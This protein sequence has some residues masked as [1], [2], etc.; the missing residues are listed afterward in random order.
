MLQ[1]SRSGDRVPFGA[2]WLS[3]ALLFAGRVPLR[4]E[5]PLHERI[6]HFIEAGTPNFGKLAAGPAPDAEF[7]RRVYLD[8]TGTIPS[9]AQARAFLADAS[10]DKRQNLIDR[11][12]ASPEY[13]R[14]MQHVFNVVLMERR[15]DRFVPQA[16][17]HE[18]LR[19]SFAANKPWDQL[20]R[21]VLSADG[22]DPKLRPPAKFYLDRGADA[23]TLTK[24]IG[25][26]FLG[27]NLQCA[28]CHDH[29]LV[30]G[31]KQEHYY[32]IFAFLNRSSIFREKTGLVVL[33][34]KAEGEVAFQSVFDPT[35]LTRRTGPRLPDAAPVKE[36]T[37]PKGKEY[38]VAP[39]VGV[40]P[41]PRFSR[42]GPLAGL[43]TARDN[44]RFKRTSANRLWALLMGRGLVHP[45]DLDHSENPPSHPKLLSLLADEFANGKY[46][47][48][49]FLR[50]VALSKT[51]Q[52]SSELPKG[53]KEIPAES[54]AVANLKPL[55]PEQLAWSLMQ[56]TGVIDGQP[57]ALGKRL[58]EQTLSASLSGYVV[59]FVK[60]FGGRPGQPE[61]GYFRST[62]E[63]TFFLT[64]GP[65]LRSWLTP[66]KG[67]LTD[68]LASLANADPVAEELYL[69]VLTRRP[70]ADERKDIADYLKGRNRDR[71]AA[72]QEIAWAVLASAEFRFNH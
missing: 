64:N 32:G 26:L 69:S 35:K 62:L 8:L 9:G 27:M 48:K 42:R 51:Y 58:N 60:I 30:N 55:S 68:R 66:R 50:E 61:T 53:V 2:L 63:Q 39:A 7:L 71:P 5:A 59:P 41:V 36:P 56:A 54:F 34:E 72:L 22:T 4:A 45:L 31:Y 6:D 67:Y 70:S 57:L 20:V 24:D 19:A 11:L 12:L 10:A 23:H 25:R 33:A 46:D 15:P 21:E 37:F 16:Q 40:R 44:V 17:W 49:H 28:Q 18:Y 13:A 14:H 52:R 29:P 47:I 43:I 38:A 65:L 1:P 3:L